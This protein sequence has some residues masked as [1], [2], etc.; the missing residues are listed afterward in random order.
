[1][2]LIK[3]SDHSCLWAQVKKKPTPTNLYDILVYRNESLLKIYFSFLY[4]KS[5]YL[6]AIQFEV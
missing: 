5:D 4:I 2:K 3:L 6:Q 1:M